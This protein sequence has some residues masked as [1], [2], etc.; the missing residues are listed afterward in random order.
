MDRIIRTPGQEIKIDR[1]ISVSVLGIEGSK[2][3]LRVNAPSTTFVGVKKNMKAKVERQKKKLPD[4]HNGL[5]E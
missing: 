2:I 4:K 5:L 1:D 3:I